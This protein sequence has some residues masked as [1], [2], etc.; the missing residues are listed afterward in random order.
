MSKNTEDGTPR[1]ILSGANHNNKMHIFS[2][3]PISADFSSRRLGSL[4]AQARL[5][6]CS[7]LPPPGRWSG[8]RAHSNVCLFVGFVFVSSFRTTPNALCTFRSVHGDSGNCSRNASHF[9]Y[10][11]LWGSRDQKT[12]FV[13]AT[14]SV[15]NGPTYHTQRK[16]G[17]LI[18][19]YII[20]HCKYFFVHEK[21]QLFQGWSITIF[22]KFS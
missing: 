3:P 20:L 10:R 16:K 1:T 13:G 18:V 19:E 12:P 11:L 21:W 2:S 22:E 15:C 4:L 17:I 8:A 5:C 14:L 7:S 6:R 9:F